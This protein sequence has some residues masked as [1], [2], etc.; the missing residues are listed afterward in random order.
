MRTKNLLKRR[1]NQVLLVAMSVMMFNSCVNYRKVSL[2][3]ES[4]KKTTQFDIE[5]PRETSY[6]IQTGDQLYIKVHSLD[7]QTNRF[8]QS[9]FPNLMNSTYLYLNSYTVDEEG[10]IGFSFVEKLKVQGQ[11]LQEAQKTIQTVL[12]EYFTDVNVM[13]KLVN[14]QVT[15]L[16][17]VNNNGTFLIQ[18]EYTNILQA[19]SLAG[20][21]SDFA[22]INR[23]KLIRQTPSG[24]TVK[25]IDLSTLDLLSQEHYHL[26]PNDVIYVDSRPVKSFTQRAVPYSLFL[27]LL[28]TGLVLYTLFGE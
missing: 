9:E 5:N 4:D 23:V 7:A 26:M 12:N 20:G 1:I 8:F 10:F 6:R 28:S 19:L 24:N 2:V 15:I 25:I 18:R 16:G 3:R 13:V 21:V 14:F 11:T 22:D 27:S 17:E